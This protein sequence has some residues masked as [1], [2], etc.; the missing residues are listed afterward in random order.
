[1]K[2]SNQVMNGQDFGEVIEALGLS[3]TGAANFLNVD[4]TTSRRWT[5][6][7]H[8][9]PLPV[10]ALLRVMAQYNISPASVVRLLERKGDYS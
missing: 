6:D 5:K 10:V 7:Q 2:E 8:P 3:K 4:E 1:M 9:I